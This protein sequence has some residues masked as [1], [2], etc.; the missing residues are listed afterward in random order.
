MERFICRWIMNNSRYFCPYL[1]NLGHR[2]CELMLFNCCHFLILI[3]HKFLNLLPLKK[4]LRLCFCTDVVFWFRCITFLGL[5]FCL[6]TWVWE[7]HSICTGWVVNGLSGEEI[8]NTGMWKIGLEHKEQCPSWSRDMIALF[9]ST[10][11]RPHLD[12]CI[13]LWSPHFRKDK[14]TQS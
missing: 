2:L 10:P 3:F 4:I 1:R 6:S 14:K 5:I 7:I 12:F 8:W 13:Q 9:Y 11:V